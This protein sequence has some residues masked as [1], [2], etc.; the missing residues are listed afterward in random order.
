MIGQNFLR[1][2]TI[3]GL[4]RR[5]KPNSNIAMYKKPGSRRRKNRSL[6]WRPMNGTN[7]SR[8]KRLNIKNR[9]HSMRPSNANNPIIFT[10]KIEELNKK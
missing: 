9:R 3:K 2:K 8:S 5:N 6:N 7:K 10:P 4:S 1:I